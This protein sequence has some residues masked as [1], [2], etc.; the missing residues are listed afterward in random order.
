MMCFP[1]D[2]GVM[3]GLLVLGALKYGYDVLA[4]PLGHASYVR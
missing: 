2:V 1:T 3:R 4:F